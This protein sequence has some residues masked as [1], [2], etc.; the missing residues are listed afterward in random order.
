MFEVKGDIPQWQ[1][2][3]NALV[4]LKVND[5]VTYEELSDALGV[6]FL[7]RRSVLDKA[8]LELQAHHLRTLI[9]VR[10][11]GYRVAEAAE[12]ETLA[13]QHHR[14]SRR[15]LGRSVAKIE[16]ADRTKL[17]REQRTKFDALELQLRQH[18]QMIKRLDSRVTAVETGV[19][20]TRRVQEDADA[21]ISE[22]FDL[23]KK[24]GIGVETDATG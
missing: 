14:K 12:H 11:V 3:Y 15:S 4:P 20:D 13:R 5:T 16:S 18:Q 7:S 8:V 6:D 24:H 19:K 2:I 23:L 22:L 17:T 1:M 21:R 9:N 10:G